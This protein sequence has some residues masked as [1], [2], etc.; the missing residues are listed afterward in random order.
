MIRINY[1]RSATGH[2]NCFDFNFNEKELI[3]S[4]YYEKGERGA[5]LRF[6]IRLLGKAGMLS[7]NAK[8]IIWSIHYP[9]HFGD[10]PFTMIYDIDYDTV[11]FAV[12]TEYCEYKEIIAEKLRSLAETA[13]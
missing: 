13:E 12:D 11:S 3:P 6:F 5:V 4:V 9:C 2:D 10:I 1:K 8:E 7:E